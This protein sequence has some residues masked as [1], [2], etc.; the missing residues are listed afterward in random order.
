MPWAGL[1]LIA[2]MVMAIDAIASPP[3]TPSP[4]GTP[5]V[6]QVTIDPNGKEPVCR[7]SAPTGSRIARE[8]CEPAS[9]LV[10]NAER[11]QLRRDIDEVR[12][13]EVLRQQSRA[14]AE[15]ETLR[16]LAGF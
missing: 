2:G 12:M 10:A 11:D 4:V 1:T 13:R 5:P 3:S 14:A 8:R 16:R 15:L 6:K 7:R 9:T